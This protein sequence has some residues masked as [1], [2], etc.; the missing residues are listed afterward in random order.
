LEIKSRFPNEQNITLLLGPSVNYKTMIEVMDHLRTAD[1]VNAGT[2]ETY[3]LFPNISIG[4]APEL[5]ADIPSTEN[6]NS[7]DAVGEIK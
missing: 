2:L 1:V 7:A 6:N 3:E 5:A 4:D